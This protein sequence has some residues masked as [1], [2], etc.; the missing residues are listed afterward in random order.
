MTTKAI[1]V[2]SLGVWAGGAA[3]VA[4][5]QQPADPVSPRSPQSGALPSYQPLVPPKDR[6]VLGAY[7]QP[8]KVGD[9]DFYFAEQ[10]PWCRLQ[11]DGVRMLK[12]VGLYGRMIPG[13][14]DLNWF[15]PANLKGLTPA[16]RSIVDSMLA[17]RWPVHS[18]QYCIAQG[19]PRPDQAAIH[20]VGD[21]WLGDG[22]PE[23]G[24]Y[25][26]EPVFHYFK[27]GRKPE[28]SMMGW[29][30]GDSLVRF[31]RDDFCPVLGRELPFYRDPQHNWTHKELRRLC[32]LYCETYAKMNV[33]RQV[34]WGMF[35]SPYYLVCRPET[36]TVG[37]K[38]ADA[39]SN[40]RG[41]GMMRQAGGRKVYFVWRGHEPTEQYA[42]LDNHPLFARP[43]R[44][45]QGYPLPHLWY[46]LFRPY[47]IGAN[48]ATVECMP[49]SLCQDPDGDG[50][51]E[52]STLGHIVKK[53]FDFIDR[54][55]ERGTPYA[56]VALLLDY[57]RSWPHLH[58]P[59]GTTYFGYNLPYD[60]ADQMNHGLLCDLV[61]PE[62]RHTRYTQGYSRT[63]PY[64]ELFDI[65]AP[66][67]DGR[68]VDPKIFEGYKVLF[69]LG[70]LEIDA[71]M[72]RI[73]E[74]YVRGGG[75]LVLNVEDLG[76]LSP[77][78]FGVTLGP[79]HRPGS[80]IKCVLDGR[81]FVEAPCS[82][83]PLELRGAEA[84]YTCDGL[85]VV[86]RHKVGTGHAVLVAP[87]YMVQDEA[88]A[89]DQ[90]PS[91][92]RQQWKKKPI[93]RFTADLLDHLTSGLSPIEVLR[94][95]QDQE[96]LSWLVNRKGDGWVVS[97]FNYSLRREE[98]VTRPITTAKVSV[99]YPY[100]AVPFQLVCRDRMQD[101]VEW[102]DVRRPSQQVVDGR[103]TVSDTIRG[104]DIRVYEF[105]P[106]RIE[107]R[108][109]TR[110]ANLA[111]K[112]PVRVS[113]VYPDYPPQ[114]ALDG[115]L[116]N[117]SFWQSGLD[118]KGRTLNILPQWL[119]VDLEKTETID[120]VFVLFHVWPGQTSE[121]RQRVY[122]FIVEASVDGQQWK[123]VVDESHNESPAR[124]EGVDRWFEPVKARYVRLTVLKNSA[125][126]G[127]Q[128]VE[129]Q[130]TGDRQGAYHVG[131]YDPTLP[132]AL[133]I[134]DSTSDYYH[135]PV[136][137]GLAGKANLHRIPENGGSTKKGLTCIDRWL[138]DEHWDVIHFNF[139]IH[140]MKLIDGKQQVSLD[141]YERNLGKLVERLKKT[142]AKLVWAS[143][144]PVTRPEVCRRED[145]VAY[146]TVAEK[147]MK[148]NGIAVNDLYAVACP[149]L[150][151]IQRADGV[152]FTT[153]GS[154]ILGRQVAT[155][156][157]RALEKVH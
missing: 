80:E 125:L 108:R 144:T 35:V 89:S 56:P 123:T 143:T 27:T 142:G 36:V 38:G 65:L 1:L 8:G 14:L 5:G 67:M 33:G 117:A 151:E 70:G 52:L 39:F 12:Q 134:G 124:P 112:T 47:L 40:A 13:H 75:T 118:P 96:D 113:S 135:E 72:A 111:I 51:Y 116:D 50:Q 81:R 147:I 44:E 154:E 94:R 156:I 91:H 23:E 53:L 130:V 11:E 37:E 46:Y 105:Q 26:L 157:L 22:M 137:E 100:K 92:F 4:V 149:R 63:A 139:G 62:H 77:S 41:R 98:L 148:A 136:R 24:L 58:Y 48:Y 140:D 121:M 64:G 45:E 28:T 152:H 103:L 78:L 90:S 84:L 95:E 155:A 18:I 128:V 54:F 110:P 29:P 104:G 129:F 83:R 97:V 88:V 43:D 127:A 34:A 17:N 74:S 32:D 31:M 150:K 49:G 21:L 101:C 61:L 60:D 9:R 153:E 132:R 6:W 30:D 69:A 71:D 59:M 85:P 145:G 141:E 73:L 146:N 68:S 25:R 57:H 99:E 122:K 20:A 126:S 10:G 16:T 119:E 86:T 102:Y 107:P 76:P 7:W 82:F 55:P 79:G 120:R 133:L 3:N 93:L 138:G 109:C 15:A 42:Y 106:R 2:V 19:R 87:R 115:R 66:N 131:A 114:N